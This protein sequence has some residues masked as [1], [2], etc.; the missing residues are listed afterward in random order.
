MLVTISCSVQLRVYV[1]L[2]SRICSPSLVVVLL[3]ALCR[4][5]LPFYPPRLLYPTAVGCG[6]EA[7]RIVDVL[8]R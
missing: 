2:A 3:L 5:L 6:G 7:A 1:L 4:R 8:V